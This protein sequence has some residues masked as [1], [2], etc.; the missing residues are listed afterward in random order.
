MRR[1][2]CQRQRERFAFFHEAQRRTM[3]LRRTTFTQSSFHKKTTAYLHYWQQ[4]TRLRERL[5]V[6]N[7]IVLTVC[8]DEAARIARTDFAQSADEEQRGTNLFWFTTKAALSL[9]HPQAVLLNDI[10]TTAAGER[11][12]VF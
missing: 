9:E 11:G 12:S 6:E 2:S 10:W 3:S 5:G 8:E 1:T 4:G 7:F